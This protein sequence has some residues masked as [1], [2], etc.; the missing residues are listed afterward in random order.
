MLI[1]TL[2]EADAYRFQS[3]WVGK[4]DHVIRMRARKSRK[5]NSS[6]IEAYGLAYGM[7]L[8][9]VDCPKRWKSTFATTHP[10]K[11]H[12]MKYAGT[13][14]SGL[15]KL[16]IPNGVRVAAIVDDFN[17][18]PHF[19][20][21][22]TTI[23]GSMYDIMHNLQLQLKDDPSKSE[24]KS[25][26]H[27]IEEWRK[28]FITLHHEEVS[29]AGYDWFKDLLGDYD[30]VIQMDVVRH[31]LVPDQ[32]LGF[33]TLKAA[34]KD[35]IENVLDTQ[36]IRVFDSIE[37]VPNDTGYEIWFEGPYEAEVLMPDEVRAASGKE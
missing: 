3:E 8:N 14:D 36:R 25:L 21:V 23:N 11:S 32:I 29:D 17:T 16:I 35:Q 22:L 4:T 30:K 34:L 2:L 31:Q 33:G 18:H 10:G 15:R 12:Y 20:S 9:G 1:R 27:D 19:T 7:E 5:P 24:L 28:A 26:I 13:K 6:P 37:Q